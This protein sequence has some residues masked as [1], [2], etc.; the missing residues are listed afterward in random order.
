MEEEDRN[1]E[2]WKGGSM[3]LRRPKE[4]L[5]RYFLFACAVTSI[6]ILLLIVVFLFREGLPLF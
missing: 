2:G 1:D 4:T 3:G 5:I 6:V